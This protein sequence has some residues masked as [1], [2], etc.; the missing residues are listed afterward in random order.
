[1]P[2]PNAVVATTPRIRPVTNASWTRVRSLGLEARVVVV[3]RAARGERSV[4][5]ISSHE[6][7][8]RA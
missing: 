4:R 7:R 1:M 5:E 6:S 2:I 8:E 3:E